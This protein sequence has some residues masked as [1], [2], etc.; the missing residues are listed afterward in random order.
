MSYSG[1]N[2]YNE[3]IAGG[4]EMQRSGWRAW[5]GRA[6]SEPREPADERFEL[7]LD[8]TCDGVWISDQHRAPR[9]RTQR[10]SQTV[11]AGLRARSSRP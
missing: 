4:R 7:A 2:R 3:I 9:D 11:S 10:G 1:D 5:A 8:V 6:A